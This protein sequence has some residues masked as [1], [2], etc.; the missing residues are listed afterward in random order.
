VLVVIGGLPAT[1]KST[2]A[3]ILAEQTKMPYL[4]VDRIEQAI[5]A[6]S[7]LSHPLGLP[8]MPWRM[9]SLGSN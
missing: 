3:R 1:E 9:S 4:R 6:W 5:V 8:A 2:I 7:S